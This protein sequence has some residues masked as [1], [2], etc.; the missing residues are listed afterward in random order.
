MA[1]VL[2]KTYASLKIKLNMLS[3]LHKDLNLSDNSLRV[4]RE[5]AEI[6]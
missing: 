5:L 3:S 6:L 4:S 2:L 1:L